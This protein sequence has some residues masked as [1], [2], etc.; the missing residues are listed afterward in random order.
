MKNGFMVLK[1]EVVSFYFGTTSCAILTPSIKSLT[2]SQIQKYDDWRRTSGNFSCL[3]PS[4]VC[5]L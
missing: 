1:N 2:E 4:P 5:S 3:S